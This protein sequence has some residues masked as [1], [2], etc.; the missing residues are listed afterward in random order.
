MILVLNSRTEMT[1]FLQIDTKKT[2]MLQSINYFQ[3]K[4]L[5]RTKDRMGSRFSHVKA[6][7]SMTNPLKVAL[8]TEF[9]IK[10]VR[11]LH[12]QP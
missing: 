8:K 7:E 5:P 1:E 11:M 9:L 12:R 4:E 3:I 2:Q 6:A 10:T